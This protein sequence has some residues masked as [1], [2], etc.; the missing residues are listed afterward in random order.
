MA[1]YT[2][3]NAT[4]WTEQALKSEMLTVVYFWHDQCPW[5]L[6]LNPIFNEITEEYKG[7]IKFLKLNILATAENRELATNQGVMGT[8]TLMFFC[9]GRSLGQTVSYMP[10]QD[11]EKVFDEM[12]GRYQHCLMQSSDLRNY[13]V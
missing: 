11:L 1:N 13:I 5:C 4:N 2:E 8:P 12:L 10:K 6:R 3:V 9:Q 7:R